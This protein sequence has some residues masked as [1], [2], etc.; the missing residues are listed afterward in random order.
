VTRGVQDDDRVDAVRDQLDGL[1]GVLAATGGTRMRSHPATLDYVAR[2]RAEGKT[3]REIRRCLKRYLARHLY[4]E[5][6]NRAQP[7]T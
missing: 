7:A 2:R 3:D 5:L 1:R 6:N 4:R